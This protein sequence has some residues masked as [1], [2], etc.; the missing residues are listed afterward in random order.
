MRWRDTARWLDG[1]GKRFVKEMGYRSV[2]HLFV[3]SSLAATVMGGQAGAG[4]AR[5]ARGNAAGVWK[6]RSVYSGR[7][8]R[9]RGGGAML[10]FFVV[11][12]VQK[13]RVPTVIFT[14]PVA[15]ATA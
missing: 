2:A 3:L 5:L 15:A 6:G 11:H 1:R 13:K 7:L 10:Q 9:A 14:C 12:R 8:P 4:P